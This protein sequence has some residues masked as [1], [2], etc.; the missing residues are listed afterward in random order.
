MVITTWPIGNVTIW[1]GASYH[2][3]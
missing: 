1:W 3:D 2:I